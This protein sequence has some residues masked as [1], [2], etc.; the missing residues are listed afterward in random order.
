MTDLDRVTLRLPSEA[1]D[2]LDEVADR[3]HDGNR[4]AAVRSALEALLAREAL[5]D[6]GEASTTASRPQAASD[7][8]EASGCEYCGDDVDSPGFCLEFEYPPE[9]DDDPEYFAGVLCRS[10]SDAIATDILVDRAITQGLGSVYS[11]L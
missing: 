4:S 2:R 10:C 3:R 7:A 5:A 8:L 1:L 6:G 11:G 9:G